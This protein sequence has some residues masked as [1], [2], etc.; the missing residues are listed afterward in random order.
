LKV[1]ERNARSS[2]V[3]ALL[4]CNKV[5]MTDLQ[6]IDWITL[7]LAPASS[8]FCFGD[9]TSLIS[10]DQRWAS[11]CEFSNECVEKLVRA[12]EVTNKNR[13]RQKLYWEC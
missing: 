4:L 13:N 8:G 12:E 11:G 5:S 9:S 1:K 2:N 3:V 10:T 6:S 7:E